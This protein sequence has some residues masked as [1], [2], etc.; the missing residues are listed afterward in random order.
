MCSRDCK[1]F[2]LAALAVVVSVNVLEFILHAVLLGPVYMRPQYMMLWNSPE[3]MAERR[4]AMLLAYL[5]F[6]V[7]FTKIYAQGYEDSKPALGQG[8]R[9]GLLAG[10]LIAPLNAL[11][12]YMVYPVSLGLASAW[13]AGGVVNCVLL[14]AVASLIYRPVKNQ[15]L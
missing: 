3:A 9:F 8:L 2:G 14:G 1:K 10:L 13:M 4:W 5:I 15:S 11:V 7:V 12:E 6:G